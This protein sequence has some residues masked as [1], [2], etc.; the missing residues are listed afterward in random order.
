MFF[1]NRQQFVVTIV[2]HVNKTF[3]REYVIN[4]C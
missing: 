3:L 2:E 1:L 4:I